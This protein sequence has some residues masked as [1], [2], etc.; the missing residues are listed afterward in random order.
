M[1]PVEVAAPAS[2]LYLFVSLV[3]NGLRATHTHTNTFIEK[4]V[5]WRR[6]KG[7]EAFICCFTL[8]RLLASAGN[9]QR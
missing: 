4:Q 3:C 1:W 2:P 6:G 7:S 5:R 9:P 8:N